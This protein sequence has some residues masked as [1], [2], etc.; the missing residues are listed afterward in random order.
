[1]RLAR[2]RIEHDAR[3]PA[4]DQVVEERDVEL[5]LGSRLVQRVDADRATDRHRQEDVDEHRE[6]RGR[7]QCERGVPLRVVVLRGEAR[8]DLDSVR[9]PGVQEQPDEGDSPTAPRAADRPVEVRAVPVTPDERDEDEHEQ[10]D[11]EQR[12]GDVADPQRRLDAE[13]VEGPDADDQADRD[14]VSQ[15]EVVV[16]DRE[17][18]VR[19]RA[20][21]PLRD[22]QVADQLAEDREH[23]RPADP[24]PE[25]RDRPDQREVPP[26]ALVGVERDPARLLG[27]HRSGLGVDPVLHEP[28][29]GRDAPER[30]RAPGTEGAERE[31]DEADQEARIA[32]RDDEPVVPAKRLE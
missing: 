6:H 23:D 15:A 20:G 17:V 7:P 19:G 30:H 1:M 11:H 26:P 2:T 18:D 14:H 22:D 5:A 3:Q 32:E 16:P 24:V 28:D 8:R 21:E 10:R 25:R 29:H 12:P 27:E 4:S 9:R 13:D 31:A